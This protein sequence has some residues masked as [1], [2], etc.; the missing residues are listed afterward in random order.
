M[1][2]AIMSGKRTL[3]GKAVC[4]IFQVKPARLRAICNYLG[5]IGEKRGNALWFNSDDCDKIAAHLRGGR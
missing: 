2:I 5:N 4:E 3:Q 1:Q